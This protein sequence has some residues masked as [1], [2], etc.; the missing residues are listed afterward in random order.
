MDDL[1][2][3]WS[4]SACWLAL[5]SACLSLCPTA[6][7]AEPTSTELAVARRL[8]QE[9]T[10]FERRRSF[11][12]AI[13]KLRDALE[14][15]ETPGLRFHL[16]HCE[17]KVGLLVEAML[18]YERA[19]DLL[20]SGVRADDVEQLLGP[21]RRALEA[22]L[23]TLRIAVPG[24]LEQL[25]VSLNRRTVSRAIVDRAAPI[26]PGSYRVEV[27]ATG[28]LPFVKVIKITEGEHAVIRADLAEP[29]RAEEKPSVD[30]AARG[31]SARNILLLGESVF[32]LAGLGIGVG[33][34]FVRQAASNRYQKAQ[35]D[36]ERI[37]GDPGRS[38]CT[39]PTDTAVA[40]ACEALNDSA[41]DHQRA[42]VLTYVGLAGAG[43]GTASIVLT[44]LIWKE[45]KFAP[46]VSAMF[47][48]GGATL[49]LGGP[50]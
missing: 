22:R 11:P 41:S 42:R 48:P 29:Q 14:I 44:L 10:D 15:K 8:F 7:A 9:A 26:N 1:T 40:A 32:T 19:A 33:H 6:L 13:A 47:R 37:A 3:V 16:A 50:F 25:R 43:L 30:G 35:G 38:S 4:R 45:P 5:V 20:A 24:G 21:A 34:F 39:M 17:E 12:E 2:P 46:K 49:V 18:D 31:S 27:A 23:P 36:I 28:Y